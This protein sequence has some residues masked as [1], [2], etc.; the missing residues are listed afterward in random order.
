MCVF[1]RVGLSDCDCTCRRM[2]GFL[3]VLVNAGLA[4]CVSLWP[5]EEVFNSKR[6]SIYTSPWLDL[7]LKGERTL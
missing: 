7:Q 4:P 3:Y 1:M 5:C 2:C 6:H